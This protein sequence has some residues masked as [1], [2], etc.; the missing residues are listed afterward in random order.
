MKESFYIVENGEYKA[1]YYINE[2]ENENGF[3]DGE[4]KKKINHVHC[5]VIVYKGMD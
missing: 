4:F 1:N 3:V 2:K 5:D